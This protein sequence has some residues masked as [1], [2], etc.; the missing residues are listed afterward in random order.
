MEAIMDGK[1]VSRYR[2]H[3]GVGR[4]HGRVK[5][6]GGDHGLRRHFSHYHGHC[7]GRDGGSVLEA[8][9]R[10]KLIGDGWVEPTLTKVSGHMKAPP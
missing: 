6:D 5:S 2:G 4:G 9:D 8:K 7:G 10:L 1:V 3:C